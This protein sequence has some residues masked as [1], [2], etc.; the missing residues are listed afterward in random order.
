[1]DTWLVLALSNKNNVTI[2]LAHVYAFLLDVCPGIQLL[3]HRACICSALAD[4]YKHV[5]ASANYAN[6][7]PAARHNTRVFQLLHIL[8]NEWSCQSF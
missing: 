3:G 6:Y 8:A 4:I 7:I 5:V 1:M 2:F